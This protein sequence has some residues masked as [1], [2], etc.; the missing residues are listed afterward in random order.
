MTT[1]LDKAPPPPEVKAISTGL[2]GLDY[3]LALAGSGDAAELAQSVHNTAERLGV[4]LQ[5]V[6][7]NMV[8]PLGDIVD[9]QLTR[10]GH[11]LTDLRGK[12]MARQFEDERATVQL[13]L[14][15]P[16]AC[17][18]TLA[19]VPGLRLIMP[20]TRSRSRSKLARIGP[21]STRPRGR[22]MRIGSTK[23][24]LTTIS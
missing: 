15:F 17:A 10:A 16:T 2:P 18:A 12:V 1:V 5:G 9:R 8:M 3:E 22:R 23:R 20:S 13:R 11:S 14:Q 19:G 7:P 4:P 21:S 24:P 6:L